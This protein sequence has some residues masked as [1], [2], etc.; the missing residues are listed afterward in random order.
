MTNITEN[1]DIYELPDGTTIRI[2]DIES[3]G[4]IDIPVVD[5]W[6]VIGY[7][8]AM[9][10]KLLGTKVPETDPQWPRCPKCATALFETTDYPGDCYY[11]ATCSR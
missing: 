6:Y 10:V 11:C 2:L 1:I 7:L 8:S 4:I 3:D 5:L 9:A